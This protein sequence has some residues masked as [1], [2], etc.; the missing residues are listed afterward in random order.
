MQAMADDFSDFDADLEIARVTGRGRGGPARP[1]V[2]SYEWQCEEGA[3]LH[4]W[5]AWAERLREF[6]RRYRGRE[7]PKGWF[8]IQQRRVADKLCA[9]Y[10]HWAP[11]GRFLAWRQKRLQ[12]L[13]RVE[14]AKAME[15]R[16]PWE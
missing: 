11:D 14:E 2:G 3:L 4:A 12:E 13:G 1:E 6:R 8:S 15:G 5:L 9:E 10:G 16:M 7:A